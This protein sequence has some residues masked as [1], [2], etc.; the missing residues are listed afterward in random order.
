MK[1]IE[2]ILRAIIIHDGKI[3]LCVN[4]ETR[5]YYLPGGH[6][7]FGETVDECLRREMREEIDREI[8]GIEILAPLENFYTRDGERL[9]EI[10]LIVRTTVLGDGLESIKALESHVT[11][12]WVPIGRLSEIK[13]LPES[14]RKY[15]INEVL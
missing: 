8:G 3:L 11:Y 15:I 5:T 12:A 14:I 10:N 9:H 1:T 6:L 7:E 4:P 13:L 2:I